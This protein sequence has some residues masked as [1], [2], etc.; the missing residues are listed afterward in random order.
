MRDLSKK[1]VIASQPTNEIVVHE[2]VCPSTDV[3]V[4]IIRNFASEAPCVNKSNSLSFRIEFINFDAG[5]S[6]ESISSQQSISIKCTYT[7]NLKI[8]KV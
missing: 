6:F 7:L 3:D 8:E 5:I 4:K 1:L 2:A